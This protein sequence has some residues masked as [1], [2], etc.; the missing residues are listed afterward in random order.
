MIR[1]RRIAC[2]HNLAARLGEIVEQT[3][4]PADRA[5]NRPSIMVE[6]L[7]AVAII[8]QEHPYGIVDWEFPSHS[9]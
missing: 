3:L 4:A 8:D 7:R 2:R 1:R 5:L 9:R 6:M